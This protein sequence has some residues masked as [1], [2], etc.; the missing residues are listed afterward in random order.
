MIWV[1]YGQKMGSWGQKLQWF[2]FINMNNK[3]IRSSWLSF[4][5]IDSRHLTQ[6]FSIVR[7]ITFDIIPFI[8]TSVVCDKQTIFI[9]TSI[10]W[11]A[12]SPIWVCTDRN[13]TALPNPMTV[14]ENKIIQ[15]K[16]SQTGN[17]R[18]FLSLKFY[19]KSI[20]ANYHFEIFIKNILYLRLS[21]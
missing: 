8:I 16:T 19:V 20:L 5:S 15:M 21:S 11:L 9:S 1:L 18:I 7:L 3:W 17:S 2:L 12:R 6:R 4:S 13:T 14:L 10:G